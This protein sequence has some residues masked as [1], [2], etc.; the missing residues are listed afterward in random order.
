VPEEFGLIY[1][2]LAKSVVGTKSDVLRA[3][4]ACILRGSPSGA[5]APQGSHLRMTELIQRKFT[6][7]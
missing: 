5:S 1:R 3:S 7:P 4:R 2:S 6:T